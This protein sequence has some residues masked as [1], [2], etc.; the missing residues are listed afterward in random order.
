MRGGAW[1]HGS[2]HQPKRQ[3]VDY[4]R[5]V[6]TEDAMRSVVCDGQWYRVGRWFGV[7][8]DPDAMQAMAHQDRNKSSMPHNFPF[9]KSKLIHS[10]IRSV[11][12]IEY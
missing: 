8:G 4:Q 1:R 7:A 11:G 3:N 9:V 12:R 2:D 5:Y 10:L 6:R